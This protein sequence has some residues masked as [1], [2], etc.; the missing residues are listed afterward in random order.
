M[1]ELERSLERTRAGQILLLAAST[2]VFA[3][4]LFTY[5][6]L[7]G[8]DSQ[9]ELYT[10]SGGAACLAVVLV[11]GALWVQRRVAGRRS[12]ALGCAAIALS[13]AVGFLVLQVSGLHQ[14]HGRG[15]GLRSSPVAT[16][17]HV[18]VAVHGLYAITGT[19][20]IGYDVV[21]RLRTVRAG[22]PPGWGWYWWFV[23]TVWLIS[24]AMVQL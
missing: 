4:L 24:F 10:F 12:L 3:P 7:R 18:L 2:M 15:A 8:R 1:S 9:A 17:Y 21:Q 13:A 16:V 23:A 14:L 19:L 6:M 22:E 5:A 11:A 20:A